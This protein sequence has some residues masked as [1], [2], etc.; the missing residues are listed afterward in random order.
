MRSRRSFVY[1]A[2]KK[3]GLL[4]PFRSFEE[5]V[6][7][8]FCHGGGSGWGE[9]QRMSGRSYEEPG[10]FSSMHVTLRLIPLF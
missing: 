9:K 2:R 1:L 10:L 5:R 4:S 7:V 3:G 8:G 6:L